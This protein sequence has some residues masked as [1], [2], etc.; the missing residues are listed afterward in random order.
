MSKKKLTWVLCWVIGAIIW[1]ITAWFSF[2]EG[3]VGFASIQAI[4]SVSF[5]IRAVINM[6]NKTINND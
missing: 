1:A 6:K 4:L 2:A 3:K 5:V